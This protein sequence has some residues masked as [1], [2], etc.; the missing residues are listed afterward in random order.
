[1]YVLLPLIL[2][3]CRRQQSLEPRG[4]IH[5]SDDLKPILLC[6]VNIIWDVLGLLDLLLDGMT[7]RLD[8]KCFIDL[9]TNCIVSAKYEML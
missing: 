5:T 8:C 6:R 3:P 9:R 4:V 7:S 2:H 1:M